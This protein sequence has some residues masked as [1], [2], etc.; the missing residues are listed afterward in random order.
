M[1]RAV[2]A[3]LLGIFTISGC[4]TGSE[5]A[6]TPEV[7]SPPSNLQETPNENISELSF[8][9]NGEAITQPGTLYQSELQRFSMYLLPGYGG[10]TD[11]VEKLDMIWN[12]DSDQEKIVIKNLGKVDQQQIVDTVKKDLLSK[13]GFVEEDLS[14][15]NN[16]FFHNAVIL[17]GKNAAEKSIVIIGPIMGEIF[18]IQVNLSTTLI[19][20]EHLFSMIETIQLVK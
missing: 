12:S 10:H 2:I 13:Y 7:P 16:K 6:E 19:H 4:S 11:S 8:V 5:L 3:F 17:Q 20:D 15:R 1:K 14:K 18:E 9:V